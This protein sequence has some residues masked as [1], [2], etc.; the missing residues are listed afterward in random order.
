MSVDFST[1]VGFG[2]MLTPDEYKT[3]RQYALDHDS[4]C[5]IEDEF[6]YV[7]AYTDDSPRFL[8]EIFSDI[9]PGEYVTMDIVIYPPSFDPEVFS[10][11]YAEILTTCGID[12]TPES[13]WETPKLY[14]MHRV[15]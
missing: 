11:K 9:E 14:V 4:W 12:I 13:K 7:D 3:M 5:E 15:W 1:C 2:Y 10:R 8:G 6:Q